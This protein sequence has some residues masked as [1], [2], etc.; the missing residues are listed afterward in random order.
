MRSWQNWKH[1]ETSLGYGSTLTCEPLSCVGQEQALLCYGTRAWVH[2]DRSGHACRR[3][4]PL[5]W[6]EATQQ[7]LQVSCLWHSACLQVTLCRSPA[8]V[9]CMAQPTLQL[10]DQP[11]CGCHC[12]DAFYAAVEELDNPQ[13]V[14]FSGCLPLAR[15]TLIP[16]A[17]L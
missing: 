3:P 5:C 2:V 12:R 8:V 15:A 16:N 6:A 7:D 4:A 13:L 17:H 9:C 1:A 11:L 14:S 10:V